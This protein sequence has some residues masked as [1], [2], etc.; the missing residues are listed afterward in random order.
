MA[1][2]LFKSLQDKAVR[3]GERAVSGLTKGDEKT[4][5]ALLTALQSVRGGRRV[6]DEHRTRLLGAVGLATRGDL[7]RV[8]RKLGQLQK[9]MSRVLEA[10]R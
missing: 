9:R 1:E 10:V 8:S 5:E 2:S 7:D 4:D 6:L 3:L